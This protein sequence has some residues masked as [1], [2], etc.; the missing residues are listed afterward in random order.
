[1]D[2]RVAKAI[3]Q[4][5][6]LRYCQAGVQAKVKAILG[7]IYAGGLYGVE[8]AQLSPA[9]LAT[10]SAAVIDAFRSRN[11]DHNAD[12]F[13]ATVAQC[14]DEIDPTAQILCRRVMQMRRTACKREGADIRFRDTLLKYCLLYTSPSPRDGLLSRMPSSA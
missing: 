9:K 12:R 7:K 8:A 14:K 4:L 11:N 13:Y 2:D 10:L 5:K 1:M 6:R 3:M